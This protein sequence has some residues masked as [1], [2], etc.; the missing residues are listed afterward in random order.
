MSGS[1]ARVVFFQSLFLGVVWIGGCADAVIDPC[2][3]VVCDDGNQ[4]TVDGSCDL[5]TGLCT[6]G[7][8]EPADTACNANGGQFCDGAGRCVECNRTAQC[9]DD[10]NECTTVLCAMAACSVDNVEDGSS[11]TFDGASGMCEVGVCVKTPLGPC[12]P[13]PCEDRGECV[14]DA[15]DPE[16]GACSYLNAPDGM[17]CANGSGECDS[18]VCNR[19]ATVNCD[20]G[21]DCTSD[22]VCNPSTQMCEGRGD[23]P[24]NTLCNDDTGFCDGFGN[25]V[26]CNES[27]QCSDDQNVCTAAVCTAHTCGVQDVG[28]SCFVNGSPGNCQGGVCVE[29]PKC[30]NPYP[31]EDRGECIDDQCD[32]ETGEC[33]YPNA[34]D[35]QSCGDDAG[36]CMSGKCEYCGSVICDDQN[37]CTR[38]G[39]CNPETGQCDGRDNE[40]V[41][42]PCS[43][44][45]GRFCDGTGTCVDCNSAQQC[46][47][48]SQCTE[49]ECANNACNTFATAPDS[50]CNQDGGSYCDGSGSC[51]EC[52][53]TAQCPDDS[54]V[55]TITT[56]DASACVPQDADGIQCDFEE[57]LDGICSGG[58]CEDANLCEPNYPC[59]T[60]GRPC[61]VDTCNT[62]DGSCTYP[63][64]TNGTLCS[65]NDRPGECVDGACDLCAPKN[66]C[67][68]TN[69]CTV[70]ESCDPGTGECS[71]AT[72]GDG[73]SCGVAARVCLG[74]NCVSDV[75]GRVYYPAYNT[76]GQKSD[77]ADGT[78]FSLNNPTPWMWGLGG[79]YFNTY[80]TNDYEVDN[81]TSGWYD[82][83]GWAR[84]GID[85]ANNYYWRFLSQELPI[86]TTI[87]YLSDTQ[88]SGSR[89]DRVIG[90]LPAGY[91][92]VL[93]GFNVN[94][95]G[96]NQTK[97]KRL[98]FRVYEAGPNV[99]L[100][101][102]FADNTPDNDPFYW[103]LR[104]ALVPSHRVT[105]SGYKTGSDLGQ[106]QVSVIGQRAALQGFHMYFADDE[107]VDRVGVRIRDNILF[108]DFRDKSP[109]S[110][111]YQV[112]WVELE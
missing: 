49:N 44:N 104:W 62:A 45:D 86:G 32:D 43:E 30:T 71:F 11:C 6:G 68:D 102:R 79:F 19:C 101:V 58:I 91:T 60:D 51:V 98:Q 82:G 56:C 12:E 89:L 66:Y 59:N 42:T 48:G 23:A 105:H 57:K 54:N 25:C 111:T 74:G 34:P 90:G 24:I 92:P 106:A 40:P 95:S 53:G 52:N 65:K 29:S 94:R 37:E 4:C 2:M 112:W 36:E 93:V 50:P 20:D 67:A 3:N 10:G 21:D 110:F 73:E 81:I 72:K 55:C 87:H 76:S 26:E 47:D 97:L 8:D 103:S 22:G 96:S 33:S 84:Y 27:A 35:G 14:A 41:N 38:D 77:L 100:T 99:A 108:V 15:C 39:T 18:G 5:A 64:A 13:Y 107:N 46:Q 28:G 70:N 69:P 17:A 7:G 1:A 78:Y 61:I 88:T 80:G 16:S 63:N 9:S 83:G 85:S 75:L 109:D 31:C